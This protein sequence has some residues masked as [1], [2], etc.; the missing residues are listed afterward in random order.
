MYAEPVVEA[1]PEVVEPVYVEVPVAVEAVVEVPVAVEPE[2]VAPEPDPVSRVRPVGGALP[3]VDGNWWQV[4][5]GS[6]LEAA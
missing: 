2:P 6:P 1:Q 4:Q 3:E 5:L